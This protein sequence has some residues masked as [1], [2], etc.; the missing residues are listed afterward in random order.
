MRIIKIGWF[1]LSTLMASSAFASIQTAHSD[2][3]PDFKL[4]RE[5][6][7]SHRENCI[8]LFM[9][10]FSSARPK[11][12]MSQVKLERLAEGLCENIGIFNNYLAN[13]SDFVSANP[14]NNTPVMLRVRQDE[15]TGREWIEILT[16]I[17]HALF[18]D[19]H[20]A[21]TT[22]GININTHR[23]YPFSG[24]SRYAITIH[25]DDWIDKHQHDRAGTLLHWLD[26]ILARRDTRIAVVAISQHPPQYY[27]EQGYSEAAEFL[28]HFTPLRLG[29]HKERCVRELE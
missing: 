19:P 3:A 2:E 20:D 6:A 17:R 21:R 15:I 26:L 24:N 29:L 25:I 5:M 18:K 27:T 7:I 23:P 10:Y 11:I 13:N 4:S 8:V 14:L 12:Q 28:E 9:K 1:L 16:A 22:R